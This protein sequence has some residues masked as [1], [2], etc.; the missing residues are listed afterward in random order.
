MAGNTTLTCVR[1]GVGQFMNCNGVEFRA[2]M[3][4]ADPKAKPDDY[5]TDRLRVVD[6]AGQV[7]TPLLCDRSGGNDGATTLEVFYTTTGRRRLVE[8]VAL[9]FLEWRTREHELT[10]T[11]KDVPLP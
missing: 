8:P 7:L 5:L 3:K 1:G 6:A 9:E 4:S 10:F 2:E 11:L